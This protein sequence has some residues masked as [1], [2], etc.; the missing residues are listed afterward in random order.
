MKKD[1]QWVIDHLQSINNDIENMHPS[2]IICAVGYSYSKLGR[3]LKRFEL[4]KQV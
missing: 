2:D 3:V 1:L 4:D